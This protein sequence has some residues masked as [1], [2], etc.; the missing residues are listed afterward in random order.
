MGTV[1]VEWGFVC[2]LKND[3]MSMLLS[4]ALVAAAVT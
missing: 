2:T 4:L 3:W 1:G